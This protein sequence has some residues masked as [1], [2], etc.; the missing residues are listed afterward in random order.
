[1]L[2]KLTRLAPYID[3]VRAV[4]QGD[5]FAMSTARRAILEMVEEAELSTQEKLVI[6]N[7]MMMRLDRV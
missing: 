7:F 4:A 2:F 1:M 3:A 6:S 5:K